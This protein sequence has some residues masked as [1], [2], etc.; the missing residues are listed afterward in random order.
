MPLSP[1]LRSDFRSPHHDM[2]TQ[3]PQA[4]E[5]C[6]MV[7]ATME[8]HGGKDP[9]NPRCRNCCHP[10]GTFK[11]RA[12]VLEGSIEWLLSDACEEAGFPKA[13]TLAEARERAEMILCDSP[14]WE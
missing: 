11:T 13:Q 14:V 3:N 4:C 9:L 10:D 6:A 8:D 12:K 7:M 2:K 1:T 5:S